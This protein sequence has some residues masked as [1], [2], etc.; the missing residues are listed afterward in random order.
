MSELHL[1]AADNLLYFLL[2]LHA[3]DVKIYVSL[4]ADFLFRF[5][6]QFVQF[7]LKHLNS[8]LVW[9]SMHADL[10]IK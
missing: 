1:C 3:V 9:K 4:T 2:L 10:N 8:F 6:F 5:F 7:L